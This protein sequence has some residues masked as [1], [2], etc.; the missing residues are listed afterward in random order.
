MCELNLYLHTVLENQL[1]MWSGLIAYLRF[2]IRGIYRWP[3]MVQ[4]IW[5]VW[6]VWETYLLRSQIKTWNHVNRVYN[7]QREDTW[8]SPVL[9]SIMVESGTE[10]PPAPAMETWSVW[11]GDIIYKAGLLTRALYR[12]SLSQT[13]DG[14]PWILDGLWDLLVE[15]V[16]TRFNNVLDPGPAA[17]DIGWKFY[18]PVR[19]IKTNLHGSMCERICLEGNTGHSFCL[20]ASI[21][22]HWFGKWDYIYC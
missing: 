2:A 21:F 9:I 8:P 14:K 3:Y 7:V 6:S 22:H 17:T 16:H 4:T 12:A 1:V 18:K 5:P 10:L 19:S 20:S 15:R 11:K 13:I